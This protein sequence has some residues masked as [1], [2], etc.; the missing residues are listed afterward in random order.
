[1]PFWIYI[2]FVFMI[3]DVIVIIFVLWEK[4]KSKTFL[5]AE[6]EYI[7]AHWIRIIDTAPTNPLQAVI[8]ADKLLDYALSKKNITGSLGEKLKQAGYFFSDLNGLWFAHKLRNKAA[9]EFGN[10]SPIDTK[11]ALKNFK[12]ALND[13]GADL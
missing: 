7:R 13:L 10:L 1:M 12:T 9:H 8:D 5:S 2:I 11:R 4:R 6:R 3:L